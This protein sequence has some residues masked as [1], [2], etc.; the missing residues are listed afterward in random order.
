MSRKPA[1]AKVAE[2][3]FPY[4]ARACRTDIRLTPA[5][6]RE[7]AATPGLKHWW[8][9]RIIDPDHE[10]GK[11]P[12]RHLDQRYQGQSHG[13]YCYPD[14]PAASKAT[15]RCGLSAGHG[16]PHLAEAGRCDDDTGLDI[17]ITWEVGIRTSRHL[18]QPGMCKDGE[19]PDSDSDFCLLPAGHPGLHYLQESLFV[20][21]HLIPV[22]GQEYICY[23]PAGSG[24]PGDYCILGSD[25]AEPGKYHKPTA[26]YY[27]HE[28]IARL[29]KE[30]S[31]NPVTQ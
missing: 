8:E 23:A 27:A 9:D 7:I 12:Y 3:H 20:D 5:E 28:R 4:T 30:A 26:H 15:V 6:I 16:M 2:Y 21:D 10:P 29:A 1:K 22:P 25:H 11:C 19:A 13:T 24:D 31:Q 14:F 17:W 18:V